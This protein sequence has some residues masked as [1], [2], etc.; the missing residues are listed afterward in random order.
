M[1][2]VDGVTRLDRMKASDDVKVRAC[3][4]IV[5]F[6]GR[7]LWLAP[8]NFRKMLAIRRA[9]HTARVYIKDVR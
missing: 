4:D 5:Y 2:F 6:E 8:T 3:V 9:Y 7:F 1:E